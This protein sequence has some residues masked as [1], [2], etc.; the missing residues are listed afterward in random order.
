[1]A[2]ELEKSVEQLETQMR[3][4]IARARSSTRAVRVIGIILIAIVFGILSWLYSELKPYAEPKFAAETITGLASGQLEPA[5]EKLEKD[6]T[7]DAPARVEELGGILMAQLPE[8]RK[9]MERIVNGRM[10]ALADDLT[11]EVQ[12]MAEQLAKDHTDVVKE[13]FAAAKTKGNDAA[14]AKALEESLANDIAP[15]ADKVLGEFYD[16]MKEFEAELD[17]LN[18]PDKLLNKED[19]IKKTWIQAVLSTLADLI[20]GMGVEAKGA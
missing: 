5:L 2:E 12:K 19:R 1:M 18:K 11:N 16:Y 4:Q 15:H 8:I 14:I 9:S 17:R 7:A 20:E 6:L 10:D 13:V 3:E